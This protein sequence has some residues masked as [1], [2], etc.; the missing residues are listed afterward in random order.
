MLSLLTLPGK[1]GILSLSLGFPSF[2]DDI[3]YRGLV[4]CSEGGGGI[5]PKQIR[6]MNERLFFMFVK[7]HFRGHIDYRK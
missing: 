5:C 2:L 6:P 3:L 7:P 1:G 4:N